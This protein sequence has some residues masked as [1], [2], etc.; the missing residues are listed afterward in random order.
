[1]L[2]LTRVVV[3]G[4]IGA[5]LT[6]SACAPHTGPPPPDAGHDVGG[7]APKVVCDRAMRFQDPELVGVQ[8]G[9]G[10][11]LG[12]RLSADERE[13]FFTALVMN[14]F[15][16][17]HAV[18]TSTTG[19]FGTAQQLA[20]A[21]D[22]T[23]APSLGRD[24]RTLYFQRGAYAARIQVTSRTDRYSAFGV[25]ADVSGVRDGLSDPTV[26]DGQPFVTQ[27]N[28]YLYFYSTRTGNGDIFRAPV[29]GPSSV[30]VVEPLAELNTDA[31]EVF[32]TVSADGLTVYFGSNRLGG[33][34][35]LDIW[36]ASR[37]SV[38]QPFGTPA[39][40]DELNT[41]GD[42]VPTWLSADECT[43]LLFRRTGLQTEQLWYARRALTK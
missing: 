27:D 30:G 9:V 23:F 13:M 36:R 18:R 3:L 34:G 5:V 16:V 22:E 10:P 15:Q 17:F 35:G 4:G 20:L 29:L 21:M 32:A 33:L 41:S 39:T 40:V 24:G 14:G 38:V 19:P 8:V 1:M 11:N 37:A 26:F 12:A 25:P 7:D 28:G 42:D 6:G 43:L 31:V 2:A